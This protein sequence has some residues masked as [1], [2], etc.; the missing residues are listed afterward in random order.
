MQLGD[1]SMHLF[2]CILYLNSK[3]CNILSLVD[4][5]VQAGGQ[6]Q[7]AVGGD[8]EIPPLCQTNLKYACSLHKIFALFIISVLILSFPR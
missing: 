4:V 7:E 5:V 6:G 2:Y 8:V 1:I 3:C